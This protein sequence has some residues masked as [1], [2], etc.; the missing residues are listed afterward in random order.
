MTTLINA[1]TSGGLKMTSDTSGVLDI[2][3]AGSTKLTVSSTGV[4]IPVISTING[5]TSI[6]GGQVGGRRNIVING[7]MKV[8]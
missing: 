1:D 5:L 2:Q 4:D 7:E 6:N 3:S 8:A